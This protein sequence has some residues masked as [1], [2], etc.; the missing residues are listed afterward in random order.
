MPCLILAMAWNGLS[1]TVRQRQLVKGQPQRF[2]MR[3]GCM[4]EDTAALSAAG[5]HEMSMMPLPVY[6]A[7]WAGSPG[8]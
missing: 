1:C 6:E 8:L 2:R 3:K 4:E 5:A 7:A